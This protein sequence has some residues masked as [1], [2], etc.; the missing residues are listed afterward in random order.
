MALSR[1]LT[2]TTLPHYPVNGLFWS[3]H[4]R[5]MHSIECHQNGTASS[6]WAINYQCSNKSHYPAGNHHHDDSKNVLFSGHNHLLTTGTDDPTL[7]TDRVPEIISVRSSVPV[8]SRWLWPENRTFLEVVSTVLT[9]WMMAFLP[10]VSPTQ[11]SYQIIKTVSH[12]W[13]RWW[14]KISFYSRDRQ[15]VSGVLHL[16]TPC[17]VVYSLVMSQ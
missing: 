13:G 5:V 12:L 4:G 9:W 14:Q 2:S 7:I 15:L 16:S 10:S 3:Q 8:V 6:L 17:I 1:A 11:I